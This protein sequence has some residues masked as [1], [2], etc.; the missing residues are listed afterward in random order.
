MGWQRPDVPAG[1]PLGTPE[2][3][4]PRIELP[5]DDAPEQD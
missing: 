5:Q 4:F 1:T 2:V 3:L